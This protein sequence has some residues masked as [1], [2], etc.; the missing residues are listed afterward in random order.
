MTAP[1]NPLETIMADGFMQVVGDPLF[2][3]I[4]ILGF[5]GA[6]AMIQ[7][8]KLDGKLVIIVPAFILALSFFPPFI[9]LL[10]ALALAVILFHAFNKFTRG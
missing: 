6:L 1:L 9:V 2:L 7:G 8:T 4:I 5:F 3:G 10:F